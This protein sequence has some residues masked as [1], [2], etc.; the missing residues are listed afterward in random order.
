[1]FKIQRNISNRPEKFISQTHHNQNESR[2]FQQ[3][4]RRKPE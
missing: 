4:L 2:Q 1:M 3:Q